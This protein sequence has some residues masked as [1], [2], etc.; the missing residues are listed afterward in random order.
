M[1]E[2]Y[3]KKRKMKIMDSF[4]DNFRKEHLLSK[5]D[6]R[7]KILVAI[8][9]LIMV[10]SYKRVFFPLVITLLSF[11]LCLKIGIPIR[12]IILRFSQPFL[13]A[14][15][16]L[17]FK[18]FFTND[19]FVEGIMIAVRIIGAVSILILIGFAM[20]FTEFISSLSSLKIPREF[21]EIMMF[22]YRYIFLFFDCAFTIY[23]AQKNRLGYSSIRKGLYSFGILT[24]MLVLRGFEQSEKTCGAMIQ[25]G[26]TGEIPFMT[27]GRPLRKNEI[28]W[29]SLVIIFGVIL[30]MI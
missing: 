29:A 26:Y 6:P 13:M 23:N 8:A 27:K 2:T 24:G 15:A 11:I 5:V 21:I 16:V 22:A 7:V 25:R 30:W 14:I 1:E 4:S 10:L 12:T 28:A 3:R 19:G 17:L 20:P 9:L 18:L